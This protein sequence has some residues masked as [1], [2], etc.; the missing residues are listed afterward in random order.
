MGFT[1]GYAHSVS[2]VDGSGQGDSFVL[3]KRTLCYQVILIILALIMLGPLS[4][5]YTAAIDSYRETDFSN[6]WLA[7]HM[8][9][10]GQNP[11]STSAWKLALATTGAYPFNTRFQYPPGVLGCVTF[12]D[13]HRADKRSSS[14]LWESHCFYSKTRRTCCGAVSL[15]T[16]ERGAALMG[17]DKVNLPCLSFGLVEEFL[18]YDSVTCR[19]SIDR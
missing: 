3:K 12:C 17:K 7:G 9:A 18:L 2:F 8:I 15:G 14:A 1:M 11:F 4:W 16:I 5:W 13:S 10:A 6:F 19:R